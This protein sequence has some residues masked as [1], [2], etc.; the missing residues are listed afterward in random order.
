MV[1]PRNVV[2]LSDFAHVAGGAEK[3]A[4]V[5]ARALAARGV[6]VH[7]LSA[8]GPVDDELLG[9][10]GLDIRCLEQQPFFKSSGRLRAAAK[11]FWN[12]EARQALREILHGLSPAETIVHAHSYLKLLSSSTLDFALARAFPT[13]LTLHDYGIACP[14][15]NFYDH[16][17]G[18]ICTRKPLGI[19]CVA[20]QCTPRSYPVKAGLLFRAW[21]QQQVARLPQRLSAYVSVSQFSH[22][23]LRPY[24]PSSTP[25]HRVRNPVELER[26]ERVAAER[27]ARFAF[28]GRLTAEKSPELL[29]RAAALVG[30]PA[31][32][33]GD[34]ERREAVE[35]ACP[36]A[37]I[38]GWIP[39][40]EVAVHTR[41][42]R[43]ICVTSKWYEAAPLV[44]FDALAQGIPLVVSDACAAQEFVEEG[45]TGL[46]F[47]SG[48]AEHL[49]E[50]LRKLSDDAVVQRMSQ[51]AYERFWADPPTVDTHVDELLAAYAKILAR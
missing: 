11:V 14:Q 6:Q 31:L 8:I 40:E 17:R 25:V 28:V 21:I 18:E 50:C 9:V 48:D 26:F 29:A 16:A 1:A 32:F 7:I 36:E 24:L 41:T 42:A 27:N 20:A 12:T 46:L 15:Q 30:V 2:I 45:A 22:D 44:V 39:S 37:V 13:I 34:G 49:A 51:A 4:L 10:P 19:A 47:R 23:V 3:V 43:A 35:K 38:T 33:V 5:S